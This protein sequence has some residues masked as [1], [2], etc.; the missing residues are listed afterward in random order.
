MKRTFFKI[1]IVVFIFL[2]IG[3]NSKS[4][5]PVNR[6]SKLV[7]DTILMYDIEKVPFE[8]S[9][10]LEE[11]S[12][13]IFYRNMLWTLEDKGSKPKIFSIKQK[14]GKIKQ[15]IEL[16]NSKNMDWED[17]A[18]DKKNI[19]IGDFGNNDGNKSIL[20]VYKVAK[21]SIPWKGDFVVESDLIEFSYPNQHD[22]RAAFRATNF[23]CEAFLCKGDSLY[24]FTKQ[25]LDNKTSVYSVPIE[26]GSYIAKFLGSF[27]VNGLITGAD[28]SADQTKIILCGINELLP[29]IWYMTD[30]DNNS[31]FSGY[32]IKLN[33]VSLY[34]VQTEGICFENNDTLYL[35]NEKSAIPPSIFYM[36]TNELE[37]RLGIDD[38]K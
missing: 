22:Y 37:K 21:S 32:R 12:G 19:Y 4:N 33:L 27:N 26:K 9:K 1:I 10:K 17:I 24:F 5:N 28:I 3:C 11:N 25:W 38:K 23:D 6:Q 8:L 2:N 14:N 34:G 16:I 30:F 15:K 20:K 29:F 13:L 18:Q 31:F 7:M 36:S 35:S